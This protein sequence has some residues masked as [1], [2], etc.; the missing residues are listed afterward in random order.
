MTAI[1]QRVAELV[2][3]GWSVDI[4]L[5]PEQ[6]AAMY[7]PDGNAWHV[8]VDGKSPMPEATTD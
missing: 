6:C 4:V 7:D 8:E 3:Q 1:E 2:A 5:I